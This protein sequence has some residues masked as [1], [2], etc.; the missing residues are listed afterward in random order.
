LASVHWVCPSV[1]KTPR[2]A[3][4]RLAIKSRILSLSKRTGHRAFSKK[5]LSE[6]ATHWRACIMKF[7]S[8][9]E[10]AAGRLRKD[11]QRFQRALAAGAAGFNFLSTSVAGD[12]GPAFWLSIDYNGASRNCLTGRTVRAGSSSCGT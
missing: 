9:A 3:M 7:L 2:Q 6:P 11:V 4:R 8:K 5:R 10:P 12:P 1:E